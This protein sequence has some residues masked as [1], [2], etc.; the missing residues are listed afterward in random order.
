[1]PFAPGLLMVSLKVGACVVVARSSRAFPAHVVGDARTQVSEQT[2][3]R[4][5][6]RCRP[7]ARPVSRK[8]DPERR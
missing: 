5:A 8:L 7:A 3:R 6:S 2:S 4:S 1:M